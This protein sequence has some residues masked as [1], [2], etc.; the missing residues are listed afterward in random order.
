MSKFTFS[1][2]IILEDINKK[3]HYLPLE[4]GD[5]KEGLNPRILGIEID[6]VTGKKK[7]DPKSLLMD[8]S[9]KGNIIIHKTERTRELKGLPLHDIWE[10]AP[11]DVYKDGDVYKSEY[12]EDISKSIMISSASIKFPEGATYY[13][14]ASSAAATFGGRRRKRSHKRRKSRKH[15]TTRRR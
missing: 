11:R 10:V 2:G 13:K 12:F 4:G 6:M 5:G 8:I 7:L 9:S 1:K 15:R 14:L 3:Q